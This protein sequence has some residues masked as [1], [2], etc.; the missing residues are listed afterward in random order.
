MTNS[1]GAGEWRLADCH[2]AD[3]LGTP[4][5]ELKASLPLIAASGLH[6]EQLQVGSGLK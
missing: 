2:L 3:E 1:A 6:G 5:L 4:A